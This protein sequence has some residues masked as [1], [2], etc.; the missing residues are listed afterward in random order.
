[1]GAEK[2]HFDEWPFGQEAEHTSSETQK[3]PEIH[4]TNKRAVGPHEHW[5]D[6]DP[7]D[8]ILLRTQLEVAQEEE[9]PLEDTENFELVAQGS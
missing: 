8:K 5:A 4:M 9:V 2:V 6:K 3:E 7:D 1:M